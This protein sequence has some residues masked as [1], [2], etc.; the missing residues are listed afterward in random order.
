MSENYKCFE[1]NK[2]G[3]CGSEWEKTALIAVVRKDLSKVT[4]ELISVKGEGFSLWKSE[5]RVFLFEGTT[6]GNTWRW[7]QAWIHKL[8][9]ALVKDK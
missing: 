8:K 4:F 5:G 6:K 1:G 9:E 3:S 2:I 7:Y